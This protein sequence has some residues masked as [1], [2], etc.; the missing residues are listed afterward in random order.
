MNFLD[1]LETKDGQ[2]YAPIKYKQLVKECY[3]ISKNTHTSYNEVMQMSPTERQYLLNF[4]FEDAQ[5]R[6]QELQAQKDTIKANNK[7]R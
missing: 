5:R 3:L 2:P 4:L 1:P 7:R 6:E